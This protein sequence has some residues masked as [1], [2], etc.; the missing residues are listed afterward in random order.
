MASI[1]LW[2][3]KKNCHLVNVVFVSCVANCSLKFH[4]THHHVFIFYIRKIPSHRLFPPPTLHLQDAK[5]RAQLHKRN[6]ISKHQLA[7]VKVIAFFVPQLKLRFLMRQYILRKFISTLIHG[8][9]LW[10][11]ICWNNMETG[12][13]PFEPCKF[14]FILGFHP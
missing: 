3:A 7:N 2:G 12:K 1:D 8:T 4:P 9:N 13:S 14:I 11:R 10:E 5:D 6:R